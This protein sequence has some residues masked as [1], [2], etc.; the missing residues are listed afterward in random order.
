MIIVYH[1]Y[2]GT[3]SSPVAAAI[4][5][6]FLDP[7]QLPQPRQLVELPFYDRISPSDYG[8]LRFM[9]QDATGNQIYVMG[10]GYHRNL[11]KRL[12]PG[13]AGILGGDPGRIF[14]IDVYPCTNWWMKIG[15][16]LSRRLGFITI[17]R[18]LVIFGTRRA[19]P[20]L[21]G[22]VKEVWKKLARDAVSQT[23]Q[24]V[25]VERGLMN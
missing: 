17:G 22:V 16:F 7:N 6:G 5:L 21:V 18:P 2:G 24:S 13:V 14:L 23:P 9:G 11:M 12:V 20:K 8:A 1:C 10:V 19:Y 25:E 3:H 4:H 15:G